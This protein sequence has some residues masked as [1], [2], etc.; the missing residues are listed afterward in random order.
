M[1][2]NGTHLFMDHSSTMESLDVPLVGNKGLDFEAESVFN[3]EFIKVKLSD[4]FYV[5]LFFYPLDFMIICPIEIA[6][7]CD[8]YSE[9]EKINTEVLKVSVDSVVHGI[10]FFCSLT[11]KRM[12][13]QF[14]H[15]SW[16]QTER[17]LG[18]LG[19]LHY[20][21]VS[22]ISKSIS[23]A[24]NVHISNLGIAL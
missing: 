13:L 2:A 3:Q 6:S 12:F 10:F 1:D 14:S 11:N 23:K 15:L 8:R 22:D 9:F 5:M 4:Y 18:G 20:P 16:V 17:K 7:F 21:L 24:Y 19:N